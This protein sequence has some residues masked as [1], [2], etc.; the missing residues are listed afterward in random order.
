[1]VKPAVQIVIGHE[2]SMGLKHLA[3]RCRQIQDLDHELIVARTNDGADLAARRR[4]FLVSSYCRL[5]KYNI[6]TESVIWV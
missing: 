5:L 4:R 2:P 6:R 3:R 1:M